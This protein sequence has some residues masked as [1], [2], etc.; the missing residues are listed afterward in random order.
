M[1]IQFVSCTPLLHDNFPIKSVSN[2]TESITS[3]FT[4]TSNK[5]DKFHADQTK[6]ALR[7]QQESNQTATRTITFPLF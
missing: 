6:A 1:I 3:T 2:S 7:Q 4:I 5:M